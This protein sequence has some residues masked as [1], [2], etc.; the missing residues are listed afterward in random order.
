MLVPVELIAGF[1]SVLLEAKISPKEP[2]KMVTEVGKVFWR[3][4]SPI[5]HRSWTRVLNGEF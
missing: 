4:F 3:A 5:C 2:R 1:W